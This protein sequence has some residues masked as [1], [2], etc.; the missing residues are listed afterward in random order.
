MAVRTKAPDTYGAAVLRPITLV[1][2]G[3]FL[4]AT[5]GGLYG[6]LCGAMYGVINRTIEPMISWGAGFAAAGAIAGAIM[7]LCRAFDRSLNKSAPQT[8]NPSEASPEKNGRTGAVDG[9]AA[10][11]LANGRAICKSDPTCL[12]APGAPSLSAGLATVKG[13]RVWK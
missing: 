10:K 4:G 5:G 6:S 8:S 3:T 12:A 13:L 7:G 2:I 9:E 11:R 1:L